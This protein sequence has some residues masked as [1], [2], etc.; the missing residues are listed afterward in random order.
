MKAA[1]QN[2]TKDVTTKD[3]LADE[4]EVKVITAPLTP[5]T[6]IASN[7]YE[8]DITTPAIEK[9][10]TPNIYAQKALESAGEKKKELITLKDDSIEKE[11]PSDDAIAEITS[12]AIEVKD[13]VEEPSSSEL[14]EVTEAKTDNKPITP[15]KEAADSQPKETLSS[16]VFDKDSSEL[17][18]KAK[19]ELS[20]VID[21]LKQS[22]DIRV[23]IQA[24]SYAKN[25]T[26][27]D[28]RRMS[29]SRGLV[30]RSYLTEKGIKPV[31][32]DI[33]AL[34][35]NTDRTPID[36]VDIVLLD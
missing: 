9:E 26:K 25:K 36:R 13:P 23:Q 22:P 19:S 20:G 30:I 3:T 31:R 4:S 2:I 7:E 15:P 32:L 10:E 29:L 12:K 1:V 35:D 33:R 28:A 21:F 5:D 27:S 17:S 18:E 24:F 16:I 14:I 8:P 34:G 11:A 6:K